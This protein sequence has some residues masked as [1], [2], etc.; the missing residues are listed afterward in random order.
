MSEVES[1]LTKVWPC[2]TWTFLQVVE[3]Q[4]NLSYFLNGRGH[5]GMHRD[6]TLLDIF[7]TTADWM[8]IWT[9]ERLFVFLIPWVCPGWCVDLLQLHLESW[10]IRL[11][12]LLAFVLK[13][14]FYCNPNCKWRLH[15]QLVKFALNQTE[16]I[17]LEVDSGLKCLHL[18]GLTC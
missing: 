16:P 7:A 12:K 13:A 17:P 15:L 11:V 2:F 14:A 8:A 3:L 18:Y 1:G 10:T 4:A 9:Y 5:A 6:K